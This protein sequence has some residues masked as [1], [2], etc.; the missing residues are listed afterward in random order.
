MISKSTYKIDLNLEIVFQSY[1]GQ[2]KIH[3][4]KELVKKIIS[5][6]RFSK[7]FDQVVDFRFC[8]LIIDI[9]EL[10]NLVSFLKMMLEWMQTEKIYF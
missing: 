9:K 3:E 4:I 7:E 6:P 2:I 5:E 1:S 8:S 10:P